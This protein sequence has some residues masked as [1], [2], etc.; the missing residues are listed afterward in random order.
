[1][2]SVRTTT[3]T[4]VLKRKRGEQPTVKTMIS[5]L[6]GEV[7]P[8]QNH[9]LHHIANQA[10]ASGHDPIRSL[11]LHTDQQLLASR[12]VA[13]FGPADI[14]WLNVNGLKIATD[15][16]EGS[17]SPQV[18]A[19]Y[20]PHVSHTLNR[21][22]KSGDTFIDVGA[23]IG[24][25]VAHASRLVG[26]TGRVIAV[27][28]NTENCRLLL[29]TTEKNHFENVTLIPSALS[30]VGEW[31]WFGTHIGSNGGV[32]PTNSDTLS[33]GFGF[34]V[35]IR[36]LD[37]IAPIATKLIKIDVEGAEIS[38]LRSGLATLQRDRPSIIMEFSCEMIQR[39]SN[40]GPLDALTWIESLGYH[41]AVIDKTSYEPLATTA[42]QLINNWGAP[43]QIEDLLLTPL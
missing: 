26:N 21:I 40:I 37:D 34:I 18:A 25:H 13:R 28:P 14:E 35:P 11:I 20:E 2:N 29:L 43:T 4:T 16:S 23:N 6:F 31:T 1:M 9:G 3:V 22:L 36:R 30:D 41:I 39:V 32:L 12:I 17:V 5:L 8:E 27:E 33:Q 24:V 15:K 38:I 42:E 19:G 10:I 7:T